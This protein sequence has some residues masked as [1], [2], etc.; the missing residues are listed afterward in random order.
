MKNIIFD[1]SGTLMDNLTPV[2]EASMIL[3]EQL[4][5]DRITL[6]EYKKNNISPYMKFWNKYFPKLTTKKQNEMFSSA[7]QKAKQPTLYPHVKDVLQKLHSNGH[8]I[9]LLSSQP[10]EEL[11]SKCKENNIQQMF[12]EIIGDVHDKKEIISDILQKY[13]LDASNT[14]FVGDT[15]YEVEVGKHAKLITIALSW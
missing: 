15:N 4:G 10:T 5:H 11:I 1:R 2:Y 12:Y 8:K 6:D 7:I 13:H 14:L 3:F 9:I